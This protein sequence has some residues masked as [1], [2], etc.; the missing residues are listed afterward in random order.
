M[1]PQR[2]LKPEAEA[3]ASVVTKAVAR[4]AERLGVKNNTL[5]RIVGLSEPTVSRLRKGQFVIDP[6]HKSFELALLFIRLYRS[7]DAVV[8]GDDAVAAKWLTNPNTALNGTPL[9]LIQTVNGLINVIAYLDS[10]R[11]R[12]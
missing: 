4:A 8:G 5:S 10:R 6:R 3:Q 9:E 2:A 7:L 12:V 1:R 11:A